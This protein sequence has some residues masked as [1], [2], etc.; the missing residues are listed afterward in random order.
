MHYKKPFNT[1]F[2][3][4]VHRHT[5][6]ANVTGLEV[7]RLLAE[8]G[9]GSKRWTEMGEWLM[10]YLIMVATKE[11]RTYY[12]RFLND[13]QDSL[14]FIAFLAIPKRARP[15]LARNQVNL[16]K[17][18]FVFNLTTFDVHKTVCWS[19]FRV[20]SCAVL[21]PSSENQTL[22]CAFICFSSCF[23]VIRRKE[24]GALRNKFSRIAESAESHVLWWAQGEVVNKLCSGI[25][26]VV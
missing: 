22:V 14:T 15:F 13:F 10:L 9:E 17:R 23:L 2:I 8:N 3:K 21:A 16:L 6:S 20:W 7:G 5:V 26:N 4:S 11:R 18:Q 25:V 19:T 12:Q 24:H 1:H